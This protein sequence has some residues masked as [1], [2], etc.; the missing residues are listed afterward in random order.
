MT[1]DDVIQQRVRLGVLAILAEINRCDFAY[2]RQ[3]LEVTDGNLSSHLQ[4]L[5]SA[6]YVLIE[7]G[8]QGKRPRTW[9]EV[10]PR[11]RRAFD[12]H[13]GA[14]RRLVKAHRSGAAAN[15]TGATDNG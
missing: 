15:E 2:L 14:L 4:Q 1:L 3:S 6:G 8:Y 9:V 10:T 5:E 11:G 13:I 7:K 12:K